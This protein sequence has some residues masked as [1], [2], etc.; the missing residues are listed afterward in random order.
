VASIPDALEDLQ[1]VW[2]EEETGEVFL[3]CN[4]GQFY[5]HDESNRFDI[6]GNHQSRILK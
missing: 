1:E 5:A 6:V 3:T 4:N 2:I